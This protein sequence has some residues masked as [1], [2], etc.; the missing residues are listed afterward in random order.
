MESKGEEQ[1]GG[2]YRRKQLSFSPVIHSLW[3]SHLLI[4]L[5]EPRYLPI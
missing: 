5:Y 3:L 4:L 2:S 1:A